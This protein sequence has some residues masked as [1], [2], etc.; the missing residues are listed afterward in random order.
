MKSIVSLCL[1][2]S[3]IALPC[4]SYADD[5]TLTKPG[6]V[7][8]TSILGIT[9][10]ALIGAAVAGFSGSSTAAPIAIGAGVGLI[11][12]FALAALTPTSAVEEANTALQENS[13]QPCPSSAD[14]QAMQPGA[15]G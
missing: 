12:G 1:L 10:G 8:T 13:V 15:G 5:L 3:L 2:L 11:L 4:S 14:V 9:F 7:L 6:R